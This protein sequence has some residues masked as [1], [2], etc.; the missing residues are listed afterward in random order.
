MA[1][2]SGATLTGVASRYFRPAYLVGHLIAIAAFLVC[3]RLSVWQ[4]DRSEQ[5]G[6]SFQNLGYALLWPV[7]GAAFVFMWIRFLRIEREQD[8]AAEDASS[9]LD[10]LDAKARQLF[11]ESDLSVVPDDPDVERGSH[12]AQWIGYVPTDLPEDP[13]LTEYNRM[14]AEIAEK[15]RHRD[16]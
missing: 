8:T 9:D 3:L 2:D 5:A 10:D 13:K 4:F 7:F 12:G 1:A 15:D 11:A 16:R 14:L 6:G